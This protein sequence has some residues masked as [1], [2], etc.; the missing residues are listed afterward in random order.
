MS[1]KRAARATTAKRVP[2]RP[3]RDRRELWTAIVAASLIVI[4]TASLLWFLRPNRA[5]TPTVAT[6]PTPNASVDTTPT[7]APADTTPATAPADTT[8]PAGD[9]TATSGG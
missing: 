7:T 9:T 1:P 5:S 6:N 2:Y 8:P 4:A 3:R